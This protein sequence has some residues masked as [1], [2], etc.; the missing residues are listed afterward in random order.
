MSASS[1]FQ[2]MYIV[3]FASYVLLALFIVYH[4]TRYSLDRSVM[5]FTVSFFIIGT[6]LLLATNAFLFQNIPFDRFTRNANTS[7][8]S[9]SFPAS[10]GNAPFGIPAKR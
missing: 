4:L 9:V 1:V 10:N 7:S 2:I 5:L 8:G 6:L 3:A